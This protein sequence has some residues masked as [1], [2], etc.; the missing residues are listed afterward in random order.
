MDLDEI[1]RNILAVLQEDAS[2]PGAELAERVGLSDDVISGC[3]RMRRRY[4]A[5]A[6]I[7]IN[8]TGRM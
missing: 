2:L 4:P 8:V 6:G 1:D 5:I 3:E 7:A